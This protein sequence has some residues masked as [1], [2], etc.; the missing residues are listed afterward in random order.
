MDA[1]KEFRQCLL[2]VLVLMISLS[3]GACAESKLA[4]PD[5]ALGELGTTTDEPG[6]PQPPTPGL[7]ATLAGLSRYDVN[8][9]GEPIGSKAPVE[10]IAGDL[11][12]IMYGEWYEQGGYRQDCSGMFHR[13]LEQVNALCPELNFPQ[14]S[15][16]RETRQLAVWYHD[17]GQLIIIRNPVEKED[18]IKPGAVMFYGY[19]NGNYKNATME[20]LRRR[21]T[22]IEHMGVVVSVEKDADGRVRNYKLFHGISTGKTSAITTAHYR[23]WSESPYARNAKK[24]KYKPYGFWS[25]PWVAIAPIIAVE[26][27]KT[28]I[29]PYSTPAGSRFSGGHSNKGQT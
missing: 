27:T 6:A 14:V 22:G 7:E 25:Q 11:T 2:L 17:R 19:A 5:R 21:G 16:Y 24:K 10:E 23:D 20:Q 12:G 28:A 9:N 3:L 26:G 4:R 18:L 13:V 1:F 29:R 8:C 15:E